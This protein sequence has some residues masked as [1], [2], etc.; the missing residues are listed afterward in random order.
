MHW[1]ENCCS[2]AIQMRALRLLVVFSLGISS[3][4]VTPSIPIPPPSPER[5][6]F[7]IDAGLGFARFSYPATDN[8]ADATV[9]VFNRDRKVGIIAVADSSGRVAPTEP[10]AATAGNQVVVTF[11]RDEQAVSTCVRIREGA[12]SNADPCD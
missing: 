8:Y 10:F 5:M 4:C 3:S 11:E 6:Q 2:V 1:L 7:S 12:Q 9:Y